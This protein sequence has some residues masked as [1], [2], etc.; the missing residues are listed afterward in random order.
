MLRNG[1]LKPHRLW[2]LCEKSMQSQEKCQAQDVPPSSLDAM[3][4]L[5]SHER[6]VVKGQWPG[7]QKPG[8]HI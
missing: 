6:K 2:E 7:T 4:V 8:L 1:S 3:C 5:S